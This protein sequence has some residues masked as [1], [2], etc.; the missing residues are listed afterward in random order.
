MISAVSM[1]RF[2]ISARIS[3][4]KC[5]PAVGAATEP[6]VFEYNIEELEDLQA[7]VEKG[8]DWNAIV[9]IKITLALVLNPGV[10]VEEEA[11]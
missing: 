2:R 5:N 3:G 1:P 4:V 6:L 9:D 11:A 8:P 10:T 7:I